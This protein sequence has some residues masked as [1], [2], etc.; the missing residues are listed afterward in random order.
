MRFYQPETSLPVQALDI[1]VVVVVVVVV[2]V[3]FAVVVVWVL[4]ELLIPRPDGIRIRQGQQQQLQQLLPCS[5]KGKYKNLFDWDP[6]LRPCKQE[7]SFKIVRGFTFW[8]KLSFLTNLVFNCFL[9]CAFKLKCLLHFLL[10][11]IKYSYHFNKL[12]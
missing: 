8:F 3:S 5:T 9:F 7:D 10:K 6:N 4:P 12:S 1:V 11:Y 2:A